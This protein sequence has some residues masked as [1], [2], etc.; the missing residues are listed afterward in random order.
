MTAVIL[1]KEAVSQKNF[2][3]MLPNNMFSITALFFINNGPRVRNQIQ[4]NC[5]LFLFVSYIFS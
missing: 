3:F 1:V 4:I 5:L 2:V